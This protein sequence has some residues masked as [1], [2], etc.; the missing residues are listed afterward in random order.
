[1]EW[2]DMSAGRGKSL[3]TGLA[4]LCMDRAAD[5]IL[6]TDPDG[7]I[8]Y[9][10]DA[11]CEHLCHAR[12]DLLRLKLTDLDE[13]MLPQDWPAY[14]RKLKDLGSVTGET[15]YRTKDGLAIPVEV[16]ASYVEYG[17]RDYSC[18]FVRET[19]QRKRAEDRLRLAALHDGLTGLPN[20]LMLAEHLATAIYRARRHPEYQFAVMFLDID[21]FKLIN[22]SLGHQAGD[23]LL[24]AVSERIRAS[25]RG[26]DVVCSHR[27][28]SEVA[29]LGG[30]EFVV[31]L[32][33]IH[34]AEDAALVAERLQRGLAQ[35]F[36]IDGHEVHAS[37]SIGIVVGDAQYRSPEEIL[38]DADI[39]MYRAKAQG[40]ARHVVFDRRMH[41]QAVKQL[42]LESDLRKA[43]AARQF[44]AHYQPIISLATGELQSLE[45]LVRWNH[46]QRGVVPPD[47]F[48]PTAEETGLIVPMGRQ[49]LDQV[50]H[51]WAQLRGA[52]GQGPW[53][54][55]SINF[56]KREL[57]EK[58]LLDE[59]GA[60]LRRY[61]MGPEHLVVEVTETVIM[62]QTECI[63]PVLNDLKALGVK[64]A[65]DDFG[66][67]QSSLSCLHRFPLDFI[68]IDR[69]FVNN[70]AL[71]IERAAIVQAIV[72]LAHHLGIRVVAEGIETTGQ[73][74]QLQ[75]LECDYGQGYL[76][77]RPV[78]GS[79]VSSFMTP[80]TWIK[81]S[82]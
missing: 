57:M 11:A 81:L 39:A 8:L 24:V 19:T 5:S 42:H 15:H 60:A 55:M 2:S 33:S 73:L 40:R 27:S 44:T 76:F 23:R 70:M 6:W 56:S 52:F 35:P 21:R 72:T 67:G 64:L 37:A 54:T 3:A 12:E 61:A 46:P 51:Q 7:R 1:M 79:A 47:E 22:D 25:L 49:M 66:T 65:M 82:A 31:L 30:D 43:V 20:R 59:V 13:R 29:R 62:G 17:G 9:A 45:A 75:C 53:P 74:V 41:A 16:A 77:A 48:I 18:L 14:W 58:S 50:C 63:A 78:P 10:N 68:K 36:D 69:A 38:R 80:R 26:E 71:N 28:Q 34:R 4:G 32:D